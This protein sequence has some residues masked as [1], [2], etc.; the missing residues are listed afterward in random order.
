MNSF[1]VETTDEGRTLEI[2]FNRDLLDSTDFPKIDCSVVNLVSVD[3]D[4][5]YFINSTAIRAWIIWVRDC[6]KESPDIKFVFKNVR[7]IF[8]STQALSLNLIPENSWVESVYLPYFCE[9]CDKNI[10]VWFSLD[11]ILTPNPS[12]KSVAEFIAKKKCDSCQ[13]DVE[14]DALPDPIADFILKYGKPLK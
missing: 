13:Q 2:T 3:L 7:P 9:S 4:K 5:T 14:I 11:E 12:K 8:I 6:Q 1:S 10:I